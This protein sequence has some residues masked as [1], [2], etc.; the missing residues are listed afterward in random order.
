MSWC[1]GWCVTKATF[2]NMDVSPLERLHIARLGGLL[3]F[4]VPPLQSAGRKVQGA[5]C[6]V[7]NA[8]NP[9]I[10]MRG[11]GHG[12]YANNFFKKVANL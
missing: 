10:K 9:L 4:L 8:G 11:A 1:G 7:R 3:V 12:P 5:K 2:M 6:R